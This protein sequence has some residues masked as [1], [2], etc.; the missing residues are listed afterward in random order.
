MYLHSKYLLTSVYERRR[1]EI[2]RGIKS[3]RLT[4]VVSTNRAVFFCSC[5]L[6]S[7]TSSCDLRRE[8]MALYKR[9]YT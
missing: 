9:L 7:S 6:G 4:L 5:A 1:T 8:K 3:F 2:F